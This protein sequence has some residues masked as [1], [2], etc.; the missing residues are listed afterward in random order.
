[1]SA[2]D[3]EALLMAE[4]ASRV[5]SGQAKTM[6]ESWR[7]VL[8]RPRK[9]IAKAIETNQTA[10]EIALVASELSPQQEGL[11]RMSDNARALPG[12]SVSKVRN[13]R[14]ETEG[15][16]FKVPDRKP[17]ED[18]AS[19]R[20]RLLHRGISQQGATSDA[21]QAGQAGVP[22]VP[23]SSGVVNA[24]E[25]GNLARKEALLRDTSLRKAAMAELD[26][27]I[28]DGPT[29]APADMRGPDAQAKAMMKAQG[30]TYKAA[31]TQ[32]GREM[33]GKK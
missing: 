21:G 1:M 8:G 23:S 32:V 13:N 18:F 20:K 4:V 16:A 17:G 2:T 5:R 24:A 9:A 31:L 28:W 3:P 6:T 11:I 29:P 25:A 12:S 26:R 14:G 7:Q 22:S 27:P 19:Y 30:I 15:L 10:R 33:G